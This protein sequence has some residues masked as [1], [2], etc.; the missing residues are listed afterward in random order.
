[1][2]LV[3]MD[4]FEDDQYFEKFEQI[5]NMFSNFSTDGSGWNLDSIKKLMVK[6][7]KYRSMKGSSLKPLPLNLQQNRFVLI[8]RNTGHHN[9]FLY[10]FTAALHLMFGSLLVKR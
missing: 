8:I 5:L 1:M 2:T 6:V 7:A 3:A 9:Y 10:S 4:G